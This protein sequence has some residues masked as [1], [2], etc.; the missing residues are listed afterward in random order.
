MSILTRFAL[1]SVALISMSGCSM[2]YKTTGWFAYDFTEEY[3]IPY[4]MK[5][6][7]PQMA[8]A[9][10]EGLT[11]GLLAFS[12]VA[13]TPDRPAITMYMMAGACAEDRAQE[14][15]LAYLRAF[16]VQNIGEAKD[17][18]IR[19]KR[20]FALAANRQYTAYRH[21]VSQFG[22]PGKECPDLSEDEELF[23]VMGLLAGVQA[24]M[25]DVRAQGAVNVPKDIAMKATRGIQCVDNERWWGIPQATS[26]A[27]NIMLP[28]A[29][30][31]KDPWAE[32]HAASRIASAAGVRLAHAVEITVADGSGNQQQL[33]DAIRRHA[34][35]V[36]TTPSNRQYRMMDIMATRQIQAISDRL[37]TEATGARTPIGG[38]GT[39][40]D[41]A[42]TQA[43]ALDIDDL[44]ED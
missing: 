25:N 12:E 44:L 41:D 2:V 10:T 33:R 13:Y 16:R 34:A 8:C 36:K 7:D 9:M 37:W 5:G 29:E 32:M 19:E 1:L 43:P 15:G 42:R 22:E 17:A 30:S 23:W 6:D 35:S 31:D 4:S 28:D 11:G 14:E 26:A 18:R 27:V 24:V 40:W 20:Q 39:F 38:L 21:L 3:A